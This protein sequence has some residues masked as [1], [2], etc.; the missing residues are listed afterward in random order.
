MN[1]IIECELGRVSVC[2]RSR[3][4]IRAVGWWRRWYLVIRASPS[5]RPNGGRR[6]RKTRASYSPKRKCNRDPTESQAHLDPFCSGLRR[7]LMAEASSRSRY[8]AVTGERERQKSSDWAHPSPI[9]L[10]WKTHL[11]MRSFRDTRTASRWPTVMAPMNIGSRVSG[12]G[13]GDR[14]NSG[15]E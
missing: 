9:P 5:A 8:L 15:K 1:P 11:L 6:R 3:R 10:A 7:R 14:K 2:N 4:G 12:G 13:G